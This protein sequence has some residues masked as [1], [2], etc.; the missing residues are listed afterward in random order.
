MNSKTFDLLNRIARAGW[1][2]Q[3]VVSYDPNTKTSHKTEF[4]YSAI[5]STIY[6]LESRDI[7]HLL[8]FVPSD[9]SDGQ[10]ELRFKG[11]VLYD[12]KPSEN[13]SKIRLANT[14]LLLLGNY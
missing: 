4:N 6:V 13:I 10:L 12:V 8:T 2:L 11:S 7:E 1:K 14:I 9:G 5:P 3:R